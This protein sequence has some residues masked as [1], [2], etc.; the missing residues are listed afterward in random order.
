ML[1][2]RVAPSTFKAKSARGDAA[3]SEVTEISHGQVRENVSL[4]DRTISRIVVK[5]SRNK[6]RQVSNS[7][8]SEIRMALSELLGQRSIDLSRAVVHCTPQISV[9]PGCARAFQ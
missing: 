7:D 6:R 1:L 3:K 9:T 5:E 8:P 4:D 2:I